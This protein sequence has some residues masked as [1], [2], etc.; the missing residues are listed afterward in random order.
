MTGAMLSQELDLAFDQNALRETICTAS[1]APSPARADEA[2][3]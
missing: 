3:E 2:I 1:R